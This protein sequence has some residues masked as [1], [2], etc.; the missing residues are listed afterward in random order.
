MRMEK[1]EKYYLEI[2]EK[3][4]NHDN[5][6]V[7]ETLGMIRKTGNAI[8]LPLLFKLVKENKNQQ[9]LTD[10][11]QILGQ[12]KENECRKY[13]I[14]EINSNNSPETTA[15]I[16]A[17][18]WQSGLDYS[19]YINEFA[20]QFVIRDYMTAF[21]AFTVIEEWIHNSQKEDILR[22]KEYLNKS[23]NAISDDKKIL[24][25]ELVKLIDDNC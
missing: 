3:L 4:Q 8:I 2:E 13:L 25:L 9:V 7:L 12:L 16:I 20:E 11:Y 15:P 6:T 1:N 18:C 24:Y 14:D 22:C 17:S 10:T 19:E 5:K 21:E 23:S